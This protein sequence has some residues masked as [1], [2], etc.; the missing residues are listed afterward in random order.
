MNDARLVLQDEV[1]RYNDVRVHST[2]KEVPRERF[3]R[4]Q[5]EG[6]T[7]FRPLCVEK[8]YHENKDIFC[9]KTERVVDSYRKISFKTVELTVPIVPPR[10]TVTLHL[11]PDETETFVEVRMWWKQQLV[12]TQHIKAV[13]LKGV[14]F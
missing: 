6:R 9:L 7:M 11:V 4:A 12:S 3:S 5:E 8:P 14:Q 10:Q 13:L 1:K 2:T